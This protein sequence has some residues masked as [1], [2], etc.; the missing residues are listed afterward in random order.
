MR[1]EH[2][3]P[4]IRN[5]R[6]NKNFPREPK[7]YQYSLMKKDL[8]QKE[9]DDIVLRLFSRLVL[10]QPE[11]STMEVLGVSSSRIERFRVHES[12]KQLEEEEQKRDEKMW[13]TG[14][15]RRPTGATWTNTLTLLLYL[16][17]Y[18][19]MIAKPD[20]RALLSWWVGVYVYVARRV[21]SQAWTTEICTEISFPECTDLFLPRLPVSLFFFSYR[22]SLFP[23]LTIPRNELRL[24]DCR[25]QL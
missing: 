13:G 10:S 2:R 17:P 3:E 8:R 4:R 19:H 5:S 6:I 24:I 23:F 15:R 11:R 7:N 16:A 22:R 21:V 12:G 25:V 20:E 9:H 1:I 14:A 18:F